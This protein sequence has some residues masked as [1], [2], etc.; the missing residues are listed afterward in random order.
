M[1][2]AKPDE[3]IRT[4][5][6]WSDGANAGFTVGEPWE[7]I[8]QGYENSNVEG[9][10]ADPASLVSHYRQLIHLRNEHV[11]LRRGGLVTLQS[12]CKPVTGYLR[13]AP[14]GD[15]READNVLVLLNFSSRVQ[16]D[17][18]F[19]LPESELA[20]GLYT[21]QDVITGATLADLTVDA[22]GGFSDF[23]ALDAIQAQHGVILQLSQVQ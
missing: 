7:P 11:A 5:M 10:S 19:S 8:N 17:C 14:A 16:K 15:V 21:V 1:T 22:E 9:Q 18:R 23:A 12:S 13:H 6:Q 3:L 20:A 2:G 4:P